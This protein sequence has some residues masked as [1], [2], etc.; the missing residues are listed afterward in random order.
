MILL[1]TDAF[2]EVKILKYL[3]VMLNKIL[4]PKNLLTDKF[5]SFDEIIII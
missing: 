3:R 1:V 5:Q 4:M 2:K